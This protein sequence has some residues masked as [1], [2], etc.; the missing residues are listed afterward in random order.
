[1]PAPDSPAVLVAR[2]LYANNY[3]NVKSTISCM[4]CLLLCHFCLPFNSSLKKHFCLST[5]S[6]SRS[7]SF[8]IKSSHS[9]VFFLYPL[10]S[11][12][13][14][15][16][17]KTLT[18]FLTEAGLPPETGSAPSASNGWTIERILEEKKQFDASLQFEKVGDDEGKG[19]TL[20]G[21]LPPSSSLARHATSRR[22]T[23]GF[24]L[25]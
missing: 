22:N 16:T 13:S 1:M 2:Y 3:H 18:A 20:P 4:A 14:N 11:P 5:T 17:S 10:L 9:I 23:G 15:L 6:L 24:K 8:S 25:V 7:L 12:R 19:W 21:E